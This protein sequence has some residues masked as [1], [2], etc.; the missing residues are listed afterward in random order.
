MKDEY[1]SDFF[2]WVLEM[3]GEE[4]FQQVFLSP[5]VL[6]PSNVPSSI[7]IRISA[8]Y[9]SVL[10]DIFALPFHQITQLQVTCSKG[11]SKTET[12][13]CS[14]TLTV[15]ADMHFKSWQLPFTKGSAYF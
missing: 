1:L 3:L 8:V 2:L 13:E 5:D 6:C 4:F 15:S 7:L 12:L 9:D 14:K 11:P 10:M